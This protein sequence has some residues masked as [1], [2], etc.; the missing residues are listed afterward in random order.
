MSRLGRNKS[1][2]PESIGLLM[3]D[4]GRI[5]RNISAATGHG[6]VMIWVSAGAE[7]FCA[8]LDTAPDVPPEYVLGVYA[9]GAKIMDIEEDLQALRNAR[10]SSSIL[11]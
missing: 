8:P 2:L 9:M 7:I 10:V 11:F 6:E 1:R 4:V 3:D 5:A